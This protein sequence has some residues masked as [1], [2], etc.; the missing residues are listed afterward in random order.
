M[1][2]ATAAALVAATWAMGGSLAIGCGLLP[3]TAA[4][5]SDQ[6][7]IVNPDGSSDL[8]ACDEDSPPPCVWDCTT[9][10]NRVCG[11]GENNG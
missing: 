6:Q 4:Y 11:G 3:V 7:I 8:Y 1:T 5:H 2:R 10:G 9:M